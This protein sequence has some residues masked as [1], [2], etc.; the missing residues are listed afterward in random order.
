MADQKIEPCPFCG[1]ECWTERYV[2]D[3]VLECT[4]CSYI[5]QRQDTEAEAIAAHNTVSRNNAAADE[6][7]MDVKIQGHIIDSLT[8]F[9][10]DMD[11]MVW[12]EDVKDWHWSSSGDLVVAAALAKGRETMSEYDLMECETCGYPTTR[13]IIARDFMVRTLKGQHLGHPDND[14]EDEYESQ[15]PDCDARDLFEQAS[16]GVDDDL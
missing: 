10:I 16:E 12:D 3:W 14:S 7:L 9:L 13:G 11:Y 15:C 4:C 2:H 1:E 8:T 6:L 5:S